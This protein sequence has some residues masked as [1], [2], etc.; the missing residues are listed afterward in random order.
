[1]Q[2]RSLG[3]ARPVH[4]SSSAC[5]VRVTL[6]VLLL[7]TGPT[8]CS[9]ISIKSPERPLSAR[10]M[11]ARILTREL[12][13]HFIAENGRNTDEVLATEIDP[14]VINNTL[15]WE[16]GVIVTT[17]S[18]ETQLAPL[19]SL[20]DTWALALQLQGFAGTGGAGAKLFGT[21]QAAVR[22]LTDNYADG[23][24][25]LARSLL[26]TK[27]FTEYQTFV[28]DYAR[29]HPLSDL[30]FARTSVIEE[31][32]RAKGAESS[33]LDEVGTIPQALA[34][35][36]Q[37][38]QIYADTVPA[39]TMRRTQLALRETGY[40]PD[41]VRAAMARLDARMERLTAVAESAPELVR[42]AEEEVR[43]S[44]NEVMR[45]LDA[46][47]A[48]T[49]SAFHAEREALFADIESEREA[50][51][52]AV[53]AQ[54]KALTADAARIGQQ[55]VRTTGDEVRHFTRQA[56]LL[57]IALVLLVLGLPFAA[58][59]LVGRSARSPLRPG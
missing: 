26:T 35:T 46:S 25:G 23:V 58:G 39:Q 22:T 44:L 28:D 17:R 45:R 12:T 1:M 57:V 52:A 59:Y 56:M 33:L 13:T 4:R 15:R 41:D 31:W 30:K 18:A 20:L 36:S 7:L 8:G 43:Q 34:D 47:V 54:R 50:L 6:A 5:A 2:S 53:D 19:M 21:H 49:A 29:A 10:D 38:L 37:R 55:L 16:V 51:T 24:H 40:T 11:N 9:L 3:P 14:A 48:T 42:G 32:G 27:E